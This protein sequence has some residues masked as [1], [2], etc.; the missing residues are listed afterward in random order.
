MPMK[1]M[2]DAQAQ[3]VRDG[4]SVAGLLRQLEEP[5]DHVLVEVN[6]V[7]VP[8]S[9]HAVRVLAE[10]DEVEIILPAYGG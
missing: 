3:Q 10:G 7:F 1:I 6:H 8:P 5:A 2:V 9:E 4:I